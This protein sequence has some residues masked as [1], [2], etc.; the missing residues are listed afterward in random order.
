MTQ[1][2]NKPLHGDIYKCQYTGKEVAFKDAIFLGCLWPGIKG[3]YACS[4]D[5]MPAYKESRVF[6]GA[7]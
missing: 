4:P 1:T 3:V 6:K 5:A 2:L 7:V